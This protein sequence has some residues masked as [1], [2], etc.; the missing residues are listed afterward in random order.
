MVGVI[1]IELSQYLQDATNRKS[2]KGLI[3]AI[4][5]KIRQGLIQREPVQTSRSQSQPTHLV[6]GRTM[7]RT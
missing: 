1:E 5:A 6:G 7:T 4:Q 3:S 2:E